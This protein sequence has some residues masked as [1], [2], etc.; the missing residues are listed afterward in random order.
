MT[1]KKKDKLSTIE[2]HGRKLKPKEVEETENYV[3]ERFE[4]PEEKSAV[5]YRRKVVYDKQGYRHL[6]TIAILPRKGERGGRTIVTSIWHPKEEPRAKTIIETAKRK[7]I[8]R[9][10]KTLK[11]EEKEK[12]RKKKQ[13]TKDRKSKK[14]NT[15]K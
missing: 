7:G 10:S 4:P 9:K 8:Y 12:K 3:I 5:K 13:K 1:K 11:R 15:R 2:L 14:K 6:L